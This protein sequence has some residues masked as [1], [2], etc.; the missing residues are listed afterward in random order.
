M[1]QEAPACSRPGDNVQWHLNPSEEPVEGM[2]SE[3]DDF[4]DSKRQPEASTSQWRVQDTTGNKA[5]IVL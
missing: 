5:N 4:P 2:Q 3:L 1:A